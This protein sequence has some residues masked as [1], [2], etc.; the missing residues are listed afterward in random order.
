MNLIIRRS[1]IPPTTY[2]WPPGKGRIPP[3]GKLPGLYGFIE[4]TSNANG[5]CAG[6]CA[7]SGITAIAVAA[8][9]NTTLRLRCRISSSMGRGNPIHQSGPELLL[10]KRENVLRSS[11][12]PQRMRNY[13][14]GDEHQWWNDETRRCEYSCEERQRHELVTVEVGQEDAAYPEHG[15]DEDGIS[16]FSHD[17]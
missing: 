13:G 7:V 4:A 10:Q 3:P 9:T 17:K 16:D 12:A 8:T 5:F 11:E 2:V 6:A 14:N 1:G 15:D